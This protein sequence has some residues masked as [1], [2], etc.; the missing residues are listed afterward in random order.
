MKIRELK[1]KSY[2]EFIDAM[3]PHKEL[4]SLQKNFIFRGQSGN[5]PLVPIALRK[6]KQ[7]KLFSIAFKTCAEAFDNY[8]SELF[9]RQMEYTYL[10]HFYRYANTVGLKLPKTSFSSI[11]Y[12]FPNSLDNYKKVIQTEWIPEGLK[13]IAAL[14]QHYGL[15][16]RLLDW[17][18][19]INTALYFAAFNSVKDKLNGEIY[20]VRDDIVIWAIDYLN[21]ERVRFNS[22]DNAPPIQFVIPHYADNPNL[23]AQ[24]GILSY[25]K[26]EKLNDECDEIVCRDSLDKLLNQFECNHFFF[27]SVTVMYKIIIPAYENLNILK[28]ISLSGYNASRIYPS[29]NGVKMQIEE[30]IMIEQAENKIKAHHVDNDEQKKLLKLTKEFSNLTDVDQGKILER[31][32]A[33]LES[34]DIKPK[35][36]IS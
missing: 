21:L 24:K 29:Y 18:F 28:H 17:S 13:D 9:Q 7:R 12:S 25:W 14:A 32:E 35:E 1:F 23:C 20:Q 22:P 11:D 26:C 33:M 8:E 16:T 34:Y 4:N 15:P 30:D 36:N 3:K 2:D 19:D 31:I 27:N 6:E 5:F 10:I